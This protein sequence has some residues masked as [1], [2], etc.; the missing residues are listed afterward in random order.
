MGRV[1]PSRG[2][3]GYADKAATDA[4]RRWRYQLVNPET[5]YQVILPRL[6]KFRLPT[7][8]Y[9]VFGRSVVYDTDWKPVSRADLKLPLD[10]DDPVHGVFSAFS[11]REPDAAWMAMLV[12][13]NH[14]MGAGHHHSDAGMFHFSAQEVNWFVESPF[15]KSYDGNLHNH[16]LVDGTS[17]PGQFPARATYLGAALGQ[18]AAAASADLTYAYSWRWNTQ[19]PMVWDEKAALQGWEL[20]PAADILDIFQGTGRFKMRPWW[21]TYNCSNFMP[22]AR[23]VFN[24]MQYVYRSVGLVRGRHPFGIVVDDLKK[25]DKER[26]YQWTAMLGERIWWA[27]LPE[28]QENQIAL[29]RRPIP[30]PGATEP[31][32]DKF[33]ITPGPFEPVLLVTVIEPGGSGDAEIPLMQV[34]RLPAPADAGGEVKHYDRLT[35][36]ARASAPSFRILLLPVLSADVL[37]GVRRKGDDVIVEWV[38]E[39]DTVRFRTGEDHRTRFEILR[40]SQPVLNMK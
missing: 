10:F 27:D 5:Y 20:E 33:G 1:D 22:T 21:P 15:A 6:L 4:A 37:K 26:L 8:A 23:A 31:E 24:P 16:V 13:P 38:D 34:Q 19:A 25:D 30:K 14:Y 9:P 35:I 2:F 7:P 40:D 18:D 12:R 17:M 3:D 11:S 39:T 29:T 36:S 28:M 32:E